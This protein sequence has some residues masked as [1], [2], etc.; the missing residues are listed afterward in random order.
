MKDSKYQENRKIRKRR[1]QHTP[2]HSTSGSEWER[3]FRPQIVDPIELPGASNQDNIDHFICNHSGE[4]FLYVKPYH[5]FPTSSTVTLK[6]VVTPIKWHHTRH[7]FSVSKRNHQ[8]EISYMS[9]Y[10]AHNTILAFQNIQSQ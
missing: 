6:G 10:Q 8:D 9:A 4:L 3:P 5:T 1:R 7:A 2:D